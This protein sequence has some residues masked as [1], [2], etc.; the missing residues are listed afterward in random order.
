MNIDPAVFQLWFKGTINYTKWIKSNFI[1]FSS[2]IH[3]Q[4]IMDNNVEELS[5][6]IENIL[7]SNFSHIFTKARI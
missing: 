1:V 5:D 7:R 6:F 4:Y 3:I 2:V